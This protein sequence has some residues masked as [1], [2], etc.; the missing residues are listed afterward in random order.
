LDGSLEYAELET[1]Q[2][3]YFHTLMCMRGGVGG[4]KK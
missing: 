1:T 3:N 2:E 4:A